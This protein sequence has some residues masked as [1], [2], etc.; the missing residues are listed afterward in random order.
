MNAQRNKKT[1]N[2]KDEIMRRGLICLLLLLMASAS[3]SYADVLI[4]DWEASTNEG[5]YDFPTAASHGYNP[6]PDAWVDDPALQSSGEYAFDTSWST[7][8]SQSLRIKMAAASAGNQWGNKAVISVK[9]NWFD[10]S[11]LEMDVHSDGSWAQ[12]VALNLNSQTYDTLV[13]GGFA[14][15]VGGWGTEAWKSGESAQHFVLDYSAFK[16]SPYSGPTDGYINIIFQVQG[17]DDA[18]LFFDNVR[19]V[20]TYAQDPSP[21]DEARGVSLTPTLSWTAG[22]CTKSTSGHNVYLGTDFNDVNDANT[23]D[24]TGIYLGD[25][26]DPNYVITTP[27]TASTLYYWRVDEVNDS[28]GNSPW[29][30]DVWTFNTLGNLTITKCQVKAGKTQGA[31]AGDIDNIKDSFKLAGTADFPIDANQITQLDINI[32]SVADDNEIIYNQ[33]IT[34]INAYLNAAG[35]KFSYTHKI[36]KGTAG[37]I[38]RLK[39][40]FVNSKFL[41]YAKKVDLTG[42]SGNVKLELVMPEIGAVI[43]GEANE[44]IVNG[45][46]RI[47]TRL[48]RMYN[49]TLIVTKAKATHRTTASSD[50]LSVK[51]EIAVEDI[52][53]TDMNEPNLVARDV[54]FIW[55]DQ[56]FT[57]REDDFVAYKTGHRYKA[58]KLQSDANDGVI[59]AKFDL[60]KCKFTLSVKEVNNIYALP[61]HPDV[62]FSINY[63]IGDD[64]DFSETA[65]VNLVTRRSY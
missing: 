41:I 23:A 5:W 33:S 31:D 35:N 14:T 3:N 28:D 37:E 18:N 36:T 52:N 60:D 1:S 59:T 40:D 63:G 24:I 46:K 27:L 15:M 56:T 53:N 12:I 11:R 44:T 10:N 26:N 57:L 58:K 50:S 20:M 32:I 7:E 65:D 17:G 9:D 13:G 54:N 30:G 61:D 51:G 55:G 45:R 16:V 43:Y 38:Y 8:G 29:K 6:D 48:M 2:G 21:A 64:N 19:L 22:D 34:D 47:P 42:L 39:L 4:G 25:T 49:D 62:N